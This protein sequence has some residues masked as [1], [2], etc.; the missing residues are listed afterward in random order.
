MEE[1][2]TYEGQIRIPDGCGGTIW[3]SVRPSGIATPYR[4]ATRDEAAKM[5]RD[6]YPDLAPEDRRV[7]E[8]T[9]AEGAQP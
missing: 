7:L 1:Q 5:L 8:S 3:R 4:Y 9:G 6:C 2:A